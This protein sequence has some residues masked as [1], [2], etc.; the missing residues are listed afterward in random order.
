MR[1]KKMRSEESAQKTDASYLK[2]TACLTPRLTL[3]AAI[4]SI[5]FSVAAIDLKVVNA[6]IH[7]ECKTTLSGGLWQDKKTGEWMSGKVIPHPEK[8]RMILERF[9]DT[10][11]RRKK[12]CQ[13]EE[14]RTGGLKYKDTDFCLT[15]KASREE[16]RYCIITGSSSVAG[17]YNNLICPLGRIFFDSDRLYG[18]RTDSP[19]FVELSPELTTAASKFSCLRLDR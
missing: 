5:S 2:A 15:F 3:F 19:E 9:D 13:Q 7:Y 17:D 8:Y 12:D 6:P 14:R 1:I 10:E 11:G 16:T 4:F 18:V